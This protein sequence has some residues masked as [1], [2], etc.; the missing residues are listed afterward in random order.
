MVVWSWHSIYSSCQDLNLKS[1]MLAVNVGKS[2]QV[3]IA[4]LHKSRTHLEKLYSMPYNS[5]FC[6]P[7]ENSPSDTVIYSIPSH[8]CLPRAKQGTKPRP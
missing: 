6:S 5:V 3:F 4:L 2:V 8:E 1:H 7:S